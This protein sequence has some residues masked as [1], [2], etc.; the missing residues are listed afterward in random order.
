MTNDLISLA[1]K[2]TSTQLYEIFVGTRV[3]NHFPGKGVCEG[4][5]INLVEN[6]EDK[7]NG[8]IWPFLFDIKY[9]HDGKEQISLE[10]LIP[11]LIDPLRAFERLSQDTNNNVGRR[12]SLTGRED[13]DSVAACALPGADGMVGQASR[14]SH[15]SIG[16]RTRGRDAGALD[17]NPGRTKALRRTENGLR[18]AAEPCDG[19]VDGQARGD[20]VGHDRQ[21]DGRGGEEAMVDGRT[22]AAL[23]TN[24]ASTQAEQRIVGSSSIQKTA[25]RRRKT[26]EARGTESFNTSDHNIP[27]PVSEHSGC[28]LKGFPGQLRRIEMVNFMCHRHMEIELSPHVTFIS[29]QN[30]SG[31]SATLQALQCCLGVKASKTG[32]GKA[33]RDF[34]LA[35]ASDAIVRVTLWNAPCEGYET[36]R[37]D[38]F[39]DEI[40]VERVIRSNGGSSVFLK[41]RSGKTILRGRDDLESLLS[42]VCVNAA[43]P[44]N[45]MT[46]DTMRTFLAGNTHESDLQKYELYMEATQLGTIAHNLDRSKSQLNEMH[47]DIRKIEELYRNSRAELEVVEHDVKLLE[48][49]RDQREEL[50]RLEKCAVWAPVELA[51]EECRRLESRLASFPEQKEQAVKEIEQTKEEVENLKITINNKYRNL[52]SYEDRFKQLENELKAIRDAIKA[53]NGELNRHREDHRRTMEAAEK[54]RREKEMLETELKNLDADQSDVHQQAQEYEQR[55]SEA[56]RCKDE[57][58]VRVNEISKLIDEVKSRH[59]RDERTLHTQEAEVRDAAEAVHHLKNDILSLERSSKND[60]AIVHRFG[61]DD[62]MRLVSKIDVAIRQGRFHQPPI[63]PIGRYLAVRDPRWSVAVE[64]AIGRHLNN[65]LVGNRNDYDTLLRLMREASVS[66]L[67]RPVICLMRFDIPQHNIPPQEQPDAAVMTVLRQLQCTRP[68]FKAPIFN[69]LVDNSRCEKICLVP[70]INQATALASRSGRSVS[71]VYSEDGQRAYWRGNTLSKDRPHP[72]CRYPR[73]PQSDA[74]SSEVVQQLK[75][76]HQQRVRQLECLKREVQK[77]RNELSMSERQLI[78][79]EQEHIMLRKKKLEAEQQLE[80]ILRQDP[81]GFM[82]QENAAAWMNSQGHGLLDL[83]QAIADFEDRSAGIQRAIEEK[84]QLLEE[85]RRQ[86]EA[87]EHEMSQLREVCNIELD[88][89]NEDAEKLREREGRLKSLQNEFCAHEN[90]EN[91]LLEEL[92]GLEQRRDEYISLASEVCSRDEATVAR[93]AQIEHLKRSKNK[94]H[95]SKRRQNQSSNSQMDHQQLQKEEI[96]V[97]VYFSPDFLKRKTDAL[98]RKIATIEREV[99]GCLEDKLL[100]LERLRDRQYQEEEHRRCASTVYKDLRDSQRLRERKLSEIAASIQSTVNARFHDYMKKRKGTGQIKV[101]DQNKKLCMRVSYGPTRGSRGGTTIL[102]D[103]KQLSGGERSYATTAF[104]L[105]LRNE[106][107]SPFVAL[108]EVSRMPKRMFV[109]SLLMLPLHVW[110]LRMSLLGSIVNNIPYKHFN[111]YHDHCHFHHHISHYSYRYFI[112]QMDVFMDNVNRHVAIKN[113]L[114]FAQ[115]QSTLQMI[116]L[117]PLSIS[118]IDDL[119]K[120]GKVP[121]GLLKVIEL[122]S[123]RRTD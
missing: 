69:Y 47:A 59:G 99:G 11:R 49:L 29:G 78:E 77:T 31:K 109:C 101:D 121:E 18:D 113:L 93:G 75:L 83:T 119:R 57:L 118:V 89:H 80:D 44:I 17:S 112:M 88:R 64:A 34:I 41:D 94:R 61:G 8:R 85:A 9:D 27:V 90:S 68:D 117:S 1:R 7:E 110:G 106:T 115:E 111:H 25:R 114:T 33:L 73:I 32:R 48:G 79:H 50:D 4:K 96:D 23:T 86:R 13:S 62:M 95:F 19:Y 15:E 97:E 123:A 30:G 76:D 28:R 52:S 46:Q 39:G 122:Q 116:L 20:D 100:D 45:V 82:I 107:E 63:G 26:K 36:Y 35:G 42:S 102:K 37:H 3:R 38:L 6:V 120:S 103:L 5:V 70:S 72:S 10:E 22:S 43:N 55:L 81:S 16:K 98:H 58:S 24:P 105:A 65:I 51:E 53:S 21:E 40:M 56:R 108:D 71:Y 91:K 84:E 74:S 66:P 14:R 54:K 60:A 104:V 92:R 2:W 67:N 87:K 12:Q